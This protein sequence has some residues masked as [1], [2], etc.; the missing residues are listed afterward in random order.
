VAQGAPVIDAFL[1]FFVV[2][3]V[4]IAFV[5]IGGRAEHWLFVAWRGLQV[6]TLGLAFVWIGGRLVR[7]RWSDR[8]LVLAVAAA[9]GYVALSYDGIAWDAQMEYHRVLLLADRFGSL[10]AGYAHGMVPWLLGYPPG[11][12][13]SVMWYRWLRL[14][15][16]NMALDVL[17]LLWTASFVLRHM[18]KVDASGKLIFFVLMATNVT[19]QWHVTFFYNNVLYALIWAQLILAPMLGSTLRPWE[20]CAY[21]LVLVWLRPQWQIA[22][23]PLV[24]SALA[25]VVS[26]PSIDRRLLRDTILVATAAIAVAWLGGLHWY[27]VEAELDR[28]QQQLKEAVIEDVKAHQDPSLL[29]VEVETQAIEKLA[30]PPPPLF[31]SASASAIAWAWGVTKN[32]H[33]AGM[34]LMFAVGILA[35]VALRRRGIVFFVPWLSPLGLIVGTAAFARVYVNYRANTWALERMQMVVPILAAGAVTALHARLRAARR[36]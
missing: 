22:A 36:H 11:T 13:L 6:A 4:P 2:S 7:A 1:V 23:I 5:G 21:A 14:P 26:A 15:S 18:H 30:P 17:V 3:I 28:Q 16:P 9:L 34:L 10:S 27:R 12:S 32:L 8:L 29:R 35:V 31:S 20:Q 33:W 24:S 25:T 19:M